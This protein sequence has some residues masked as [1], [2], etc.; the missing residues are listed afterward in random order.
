[1]I[2]VDTSSFI[3]F[4]NNDD[5]KDVPLIADIFKNRQ[6]ILPPIVV[7]ELLSNPKLP[8]HL[9]VIIK[10]IPLLAITYGYWERTG[11]IR[12]TIIKRN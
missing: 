12:A 5:G 8:A 10:Q 1:M 2:A 4:L 9:V 6:L 11:E 3:G 7:S